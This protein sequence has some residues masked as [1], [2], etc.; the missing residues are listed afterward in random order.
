MDLGFAKEELARFLNEEL[1]LSF[2]YDYEHDRDEDEGHLRATCAIRLDGHDDHVFCDMDVY[3]NG[4]F[5]V[6]FVFDKLDA[7]P[8]VYKLLSDYNSASV[9]LT[10]M[11]REDGFLVL[12]YNVMALTE[13]CLD[14]NVRGLFD[15]LVS[16]ELRPLLAALTARTHD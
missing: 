4:S 16:D 12:R 1:E 11:L 7:S 8:E 13:D 5:G 14:D 2:E 9:W 10:A 3:E 15:E 6:D